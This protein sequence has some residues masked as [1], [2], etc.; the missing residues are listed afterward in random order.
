MNLQ[1]TIRRIL[2]E[3]TD[4]NTRLRRRIHY[5]D[6][7]IKYRMN[8]VYTPDNICRFESGEELFDVVSE[9]TIDNMYYKYF[10]DID[11][12]S[13][14][15]EKIYYLIMD[16]IQMNYGKDIMEYYHINCGD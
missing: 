12:T 15:W 2:F 14:E 5:V 9:A 16:Y 1:K 3:E 10:D 13:K 11:D 6:T 7:E 4:V 8:V